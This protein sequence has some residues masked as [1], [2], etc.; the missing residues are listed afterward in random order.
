LIEALEIIDFMTAR[1][2]RLPYGFLDNVSFRI[3]NEISRVT[4]V[5][6][7]ISGEPPAT[8]WS[9]SATDG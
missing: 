2:A 5:V 6:Y 3:I 7:G 1:W 8:I 9:N 4:R